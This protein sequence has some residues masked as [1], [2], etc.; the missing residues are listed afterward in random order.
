ERLRLVIEH[1]ALEQRHVGAL[2]RVRG[3]PEHVVGAGEEVRRRRSGLLVGGDDEDSGDDQRP[4]DG[5]ERDEPA[6]AQ[7]LLQQ[8]RVRGFLEAV[9]VLFRRGGFAHVGF[10]LA[11]S[12]ASASC[13]MVGFSSAWLCASSSGPPAIINPRTSRSVSPGT[14]PTICPRYITAIRSASAETSSSSVETMIT[15]VPESRSETIRL[16]TNSIEPTSSPR[17]GWEAMRSFSGRDIS[18]ASTTFC[19]F[20]PD[21]ELIG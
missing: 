6:R 19:W 8:V 14:M 7:H 3:V 13:M 20:P 4:H 10:L 2:D 21:R 1:R 5:K 11:H 17:V 15:G 12:S 18:R 16:C 9:A